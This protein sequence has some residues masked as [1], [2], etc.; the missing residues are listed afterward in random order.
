MTDKKKDFLKKNDNNCM[1]SFM[2]NLK[3]KMENEQKQKN[4]QTIKL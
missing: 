3:I 2:K 4:C 1:K